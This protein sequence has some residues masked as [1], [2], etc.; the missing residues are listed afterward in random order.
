MSEAIHI[1]AARDQYPFPW[2]VLMDAKDGR[3]PSASVLRK[4]LEQQESQFHKWL[5]AFR[6]DRTGGSSPPPMS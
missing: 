6:D 2:T 1:D 5:R 3:W 4:S